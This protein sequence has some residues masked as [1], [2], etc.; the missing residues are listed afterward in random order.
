M[1]KEESGYYASAPFLTARK[2][3]ASPSEPSSK[4]SIVIRNDKGVHEEAKAVGI[5]RQSDW[6]NAADPL[7]YEDMP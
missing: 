1:W 6:L 3:K 2:K 4:A 5:H 7:S